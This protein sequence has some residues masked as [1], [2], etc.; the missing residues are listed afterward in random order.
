VKVQ[1]SANGATETNFTIQLTVQGTITPP[2]INLSST[3]VALEHDQR[4]DIAVTV[5]DDYGQKLHWEASSSDDNFAAVTANIDHATITG[6]ANGMATIHFIV[7]APNGSN[8]TASLNVTIREAQPRHHPPYIN[9]MGMIFE[10]VPQLPDIPNAQW[11]DASSGASWAGNG[12]GWVAIYPV[13]QGQFKKV[14]NNQNPSKFKEGDNYPVES[15]TLDQVSEFCQNLNAGDKNKPKDWLYVLPSSLQWIRFAG[16]LPQKKGGNYTSDINYAASGK[17]KTTPVGQY[18]TN[19]YGLFDV[20]G[21]VAELTTDTIPATTVSK[22]SRF[23]R[24]GSWN[25]HVPTLANTNLNVGPNT[26]SFAD[27]AETSGFRVILV[28]AQ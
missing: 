1:A 20:F 5:G 9:Y 22:L 18:S 19:E 27:P 24:G 3:N 2:R 28:P 21:N 16:P 15:M 23:L 17:G 6:K 13:T 10:W 11:A 7:T 25:S 14:M 4:T 8:S 12:G 26:E